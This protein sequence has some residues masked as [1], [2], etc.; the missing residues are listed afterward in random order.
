MTKEKLLEL[1]KSE[2]PSQKLLEVIDFRPSKSGI[3]GVIYDVDVLVEH[4]FIYESCFKRVHE[5]MP[6]PM[7]PFKEYN[8]E[9]IKSNIEKNKEVLKDV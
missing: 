9:R 6:Y 3:K 2:R 5:D 7:K 4:R 8:D 1:M